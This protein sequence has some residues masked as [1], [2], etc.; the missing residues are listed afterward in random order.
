MNSL[1]NKTVIVD[2]QVNILDLVYLSF[3]FAMNTNI[4][5]LTQK[6]HLLTTEGIECLNK[7][8]FVFDVLDERL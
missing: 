4:I 5:K 6:R 3:G 1:L 2:Y 8:G 7:Y